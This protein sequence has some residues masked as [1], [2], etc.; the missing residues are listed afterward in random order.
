MD[1]SGRIIG[2]NL[3]VREADTG[4]LIWNVDTSWGNRAGMPA[5]LRAGQTF[6]AD[7]VSVPEFGRTFPVHPRA[8]FTV[9][10]DT[11][12]GRVEFHVP[13]SPEG[14]VRVGR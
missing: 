1:D 9:A 14:E 2:G 13:Q 12:P 7:L 4:K 8:T 3:E 5:G 10:S 11:E 6:T